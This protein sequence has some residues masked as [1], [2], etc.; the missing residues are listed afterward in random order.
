LELRDIIKEEYKRCAAD[1]VHFFRKYSTIQHPVEGKIKFNLYPFQETML[2]DLA[3]YRFNIILK[4][5][6]MGIS[7]LTA[8]IALHR[9]LF[10]SDYKVL[11]IATRQD[12]AR[13]LVQKVQ[14]MHDNLPVWL[15]QKVLE[16]NRLSLKFGNGSEIKAVSSSGTSGR[17]E[18][19]SLLVIDEAAFIDKIDEI[20]ASATLT[21]ATGGDAIILSTPNGVGNFFHKTWVKAEA[22]RAEEG[23]DVF[24][25]IR[26][27]WDLHPD[28]DA[29][30]R[31]Q[32]DDLLGK[33]LASQECDCDFISSGHTVVE[34]ETLV[35]YE[36]EMTQDP[37]EKRGQNGEL[38]IWK[39]PEANR[40][41]ILVADVSRGDGEDFSAF[42]VFDIERMEQVAEFEGMIG[43]TEYGRLLVSVATEYNTARLV[44]DNKN[45]GWSTIQTV[46]DLRYPNLHYSYKND[47]YVDENIQ[48]RKHYD[49]KDKK[50][51]VP[52]FTTTHVNRPVMISKLETII[53]SK[54]I[55]LRSKRLINQLFVFIWV[56]GKA[57][58]QNGYNDD[59]VMALA[60]FLFVRDTS[61]RMY[62]LGIEQ[63]RSAL[64]QT[65][66]AAYK[67]SSPQTSPWDMQIGARGKEKIT[68]LL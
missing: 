15:R 9:M 29:R 6:Q 2:S 45:I 58:A 12:V 8:G 32:Q 30:W 50:D 48:L 23:L 39:R 56:N 33:R 65:Y 36:K 35:W 1:P 24:N 14:V 11:V 49:L 62:Q 4:S 41:Y 55:T 42:H 40:P 68:W 54:Q 60:M 19:L 10:R 53:T 64:K 16:Q 7:T 61:L 43:T 47:P 66:K 13:N 17:S 28:R 31:K 38:W 34:G 5:R 44:I 51:M 57:Q 20:W 46:L 63:N 27:N 67:P 25:P 37:V 22:G 18:A 21:L 52:G 3:E 59:L 26:L